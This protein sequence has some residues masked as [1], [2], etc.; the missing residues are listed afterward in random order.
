MP[1]APS[2]GRRWRAVIFVRPLISLFSRRQPDL[3]FN[4][5]V[6]LDTNVLPDVLEDADIRDIDTSFQAGHHDC[7][8]DS[9]LE[10]GDI[11][12]ESKPEEQSEDEDDI[13]EEPASDGGGA[14]DADGTTNA[15]SASAP[16][17]SPADE[18]KDV[19]KDVE[20]ETQ[21]DRN[22]N[23]VAESVRPPRFEFLL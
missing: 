13:V 21:E 7:L 18:S 9:D 6:V 17:P 20:A 4:R 16:S 8:E 5:L 1:T 11:T 14:P 2:F 15:T 19:A 12:I 3:L 10:D 23:P 22:E